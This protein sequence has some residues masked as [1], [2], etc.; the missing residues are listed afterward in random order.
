MVG[1]LGLQE[2]FAGALNNPAASPPHF[3]KCASGSLSYRV[4]IYRNNVSSGL[5]N[6]LKSRFPAV[7]RIVGDE[8][9]KGLAHQ[10]VT[11]HP[12]R[13]PALIAY[14]GDFAGYIGALPEC[15][16]VPYLADVADIEWQLHRC[17]HAADSVL[18]GANDIAGLS[19]HADTLTFCFAASS[20]VLLSQYPAYTIWRANVE[21]LCERLAIGQTAEA[22][23]ITRPHLRS[24]AV[25]LPDG[26]YEFA[27]ALSARHTLAEAADLA[28]ASAPGFQLD[29]CLGLLIRQAAFS[30]VSTTA[31]EGPMP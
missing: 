13:S 30:N 17:A 10:F 6:V 5:A 15:S 28:S 29:Q 19:L 20:A 18:L 22:T 9:F 26:G 16:D 1:L 21:L 27:M 11:H 23:L 8:F 31:L 3:L 4:G 12:P 7:R 2:D 14:G 24:Q 25:C